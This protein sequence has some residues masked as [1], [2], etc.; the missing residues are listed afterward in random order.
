MFIFVTS[1]T[2]LLIEFDIEARRQVGML[3]SEGRKKQQMS[4][5]ELSRVLGYNCAQSVC[6]FEKG[7]A[8][9]PRPVL[10]DL[11]S[12]DILCEKKFKTLCLQIVKKDLSIICR[13]AS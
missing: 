13:G 6:N 10:S 5:V 8:L 3:I 11:I 9:P 12:L 4:Q 1:E 7:R 2:V